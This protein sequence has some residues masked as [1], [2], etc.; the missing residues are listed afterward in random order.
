M[1][2]AVNS[3]HGL[4]Q[5]VPQR[6]RRDE[7]ALPLALPAGAIADV[8][9]ILG[10]RL[11]PLLSDLYTTVADGGFGPDY[12][13]LGLADSST[14]DLGRSAVDGYLTFR[15]PDPEDQGGSGP[16]ESY[17]CSTGAAACT[18]AWT[19]EATAARS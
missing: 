8:E 2:Q 5:R 15:Q 3:G 4:L 19:A 9:A 11:H 16:K 14:C 13:L 6:A 10:F 17:R 7:L 18:P 12:K 1:T